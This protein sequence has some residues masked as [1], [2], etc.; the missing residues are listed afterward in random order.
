MARLLRREEQPVAKEQPVG[1]EPSPRSPTETHLRIRRGLVESVDLYEIKDTELEQLERGSPADL[2]LNF[3]IFLLSVAFAAFCAL[4]TATFPNSRIET[5]FQVVLVVGVVLG[6][7][8][9]IVWWRNRKSMLRVCRRV[10]ERMPPDVLPR[11]S[12]GPSS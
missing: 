11:G 10:R 2:Q 9:L 3:A 4:A 12:E 5:A 1:T 7:Y 8:F 6:V